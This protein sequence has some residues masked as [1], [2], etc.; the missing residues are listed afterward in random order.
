[1]NQ[2]VST[3]ESQRSPLLKLTP[4]SFRLKYWGIR[5]NQ[6]GFQDSHIHSQGIISGV[7]YL[8]VPEE[9]P[10]SQAGYLEIGATP[11]WLEPVFD[12]VRIKP[13]VGKLVLFPSYYYHRTIP[14][15]SNEERISFAFDVVPRR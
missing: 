14:T 9:D 3:R 5:F 2:Y 8:K 10:V 4:K 15:V 13:E 7:C 1:M 11:H 6:A 12:T